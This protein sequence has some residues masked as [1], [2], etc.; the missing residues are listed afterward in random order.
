MRSESYNISLSLV[1]L[2]ALICV[3][4]S[5]TNDASNID[6]P[7]AFGEA[8][9]PK[10]ITDSGKRLSGE[11]V[12]QVVADSYAPEAPSGNQTRVFTFDEEGNFKAETFTGSTLAAEEGAYL[13]D[14]R[15]ELIL[16]FDKTGGALLE[17][18]R[19]ERYNIINQTELSMRL[20]QPT[21]EFVL[22]KR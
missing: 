10:A 20:E 22:R 8:S 9:Q 11:F 17:S 4:C 5:K 19:Q 15:G 18:A 14:Q 2:L 1:G 6:L 3:C 21:K 16:Y 13:I 12:L 7:A